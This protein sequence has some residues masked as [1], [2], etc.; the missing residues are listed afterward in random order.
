MASNLRAKIQ[1]TDELLIHDINPAVTE[2]FRK[3][4]D[5]VRVAENVREVAEHAVRF[6]QPKLRS[7]VPSSL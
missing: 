7:F 4:V 2:Q 3:E 5:N 1:P 6:A